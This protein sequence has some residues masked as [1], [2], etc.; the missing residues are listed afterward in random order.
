M[1]KVLGD[2]CAVNSCAI[3]ARVSGCKGYLMADSGEIGRRR[4]STPSETLRN[5]LKQQG[6]RAAA[7]QGKTAAAQH[8]T[9]HSESGAPTV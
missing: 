7:G 5:N 4:G 9:P 3:A 1:S 2:S 8:E 6:S